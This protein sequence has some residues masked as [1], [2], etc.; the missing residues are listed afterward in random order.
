MSDAAVRRNDPCPCGSGRKYKQCCLGR[1]GEAAPAARPAAP[2]AATRR[3]PSRPATIADARR[4]AAAGEWSRAEAI[5]RA[6]L[7][8]DPRD[9]AALRGLADARLARGGGAAGA[10]EAAALLDR[11]VAV[12][13][14][15]ASLRLVQADAC[16]RAGRGG[17]ARAAAEAAV[18]LAPQDPAAGAMLAMVLE[19]TNDL[20]AAAAAIRGAEAAGPGHVSVITMAARIARRRGDLEAALQ[21][22][23]PL[24]E[25][26]DLSPFQRQVALHEQ[27]MSLEAAGRH[28]EAWAAFVA[29][30]RALAE[31]P[32]ARRLDRTAWPRRI[33][34]CRRGL[35]RE[36]L[37]KAGPVAPPPPSL[38]FRPVFLVGFPRSGT[39][40]TE[41]VLAAHPDVRTTDEQPFLGAVKRT[42]AAAVAGPP[43]DLP[44]LLARLTPPLRLRLRAEYAARVQAAMG[45]AAGRSVLVD[46]LP[47]N[48]VDIALADALFPEA[49][50]L[51]ALRDPRDVC[52]SCFQQWFEL[53]TAM[54]HFLDPEDTVRFYA[55][56]MDGWLET[57][58]HLRVPVLP[59]RYEDTTADLE[60]QARRMLEFLDLPWHPGVLA[61]HERV[62]GRAV[63]TPSY[64]AVSEPVHRRAVARWR[65]YAEAVGDWEPSL[66]RFLEAFG[67]APASAAGSSPAESDGQ[68]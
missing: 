36:L 20:P 60:A 55:Q 27:A 25:R 8:R 13:P 5:W 23:G 39:T 65:R 59:V 62:A 52:L 12:Q 66:A 26:R 37:E 3:S 21:R 34:A 53:N 61:G 45:P 22:L 48:I 29:T 14:D 11:A 63:S 42:L 9:P 32:A 10:A 35:S 51:L 15:D 40:M 17:E 50:V 16:L 6:R 56:V 28:A 30:G 7:E 24:L 47:L 58:P 1:S 57:R 54:V 49:R 41:T 64:A 18:A 31:D 2:E 43:D 68:G 4:H 67:Y 19:R 38:E 44:A 33:E 46:K